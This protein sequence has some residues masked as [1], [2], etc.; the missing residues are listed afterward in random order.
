M[1]GQIALLRDGAT[2]LRTDRGEGP[3]VVFQHG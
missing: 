2:L 1:A 3:A